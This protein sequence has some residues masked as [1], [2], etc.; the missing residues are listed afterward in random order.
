MII[1]V[2]LL[3]IGLYGCGA[4]DNDD[5]NNKEDRELVLGSTTWTSTIPPTEIVKEILEGMG[6]DIEIKEANIGAI[7]AGLATG[8]IDIYMD[9][10]YPQQTQY[11]E[12]YS[13]TIE[14]LSPIYED[15]D[16]GM[17]VPNYMEGI[18]DVEDLIGNEDMLNN[19]VI[20]IEDGDPAMDELQELID[21]YDLDLEL[22][23]SS[24]G[25]MIAAAKTSI[26]ENEP[27]LLYGW[28]PHTMFNDMGLKIL[29]NEEHPE[30]FNGSSVHPIVNEDVKKKAPDVHK[31]LGDLTISIDDMEDM[32]IKT[33]NGENSEDVAQEW[34]DNNPEWLNNN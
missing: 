29:T 16:A 2:L 25:A 17:V 31:F 27:I 12:E 11:L 9:S 28:R 13:D 23:N 14:Q 15:A 6:Y 3:L 4:T 5:G 26:D 19:E 20:A 21:A 30:Y 22:V 24:E 8:E 32:I 18:N 34:L 10:W 7:Y 1:T 33:D